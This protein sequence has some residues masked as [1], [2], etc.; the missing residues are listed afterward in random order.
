MPLKEGERERMA[1]QVGMME[2]AKGVWRSWHKGE[3]ERE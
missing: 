2:G 1:W 3:R